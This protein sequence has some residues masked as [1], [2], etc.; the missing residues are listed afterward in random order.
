MIQRIQSVYLLLVAGLMLAILFVPLA[1][2]AGGGAEF[3]FKAL[4]IVE[5]ESQQVFFDTWPVLIPAVAVVVNALTT[6]FLYK[7]RPLQIKLASSNIILILA[8]FCAFFYYAWD[9]MKLYSCQIKPGFFLALPLIALVLNL[10][11]VKA[12]KKDEDMIKSL[13]RIR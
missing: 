10:L 4:G 13:N 6:I 8:F 11:A 2:F 1:T 5:K 12:I 7:K 9:F 3:V